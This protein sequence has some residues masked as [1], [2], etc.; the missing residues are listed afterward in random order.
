MRAFVTR[1]TAVERAARINAGTYVIR[2]GSC[3]HAMRKKPARASCEN[4]PAP[5]RTEDAIV[6]DIR[7]AS[8]RYGGTHDSLRV[9]HSY[10]RLFLARRYFFLDGFF[11]PIFRRAGVCAACG[12]IGPYDSHSASIPRVLISEV[13][14]LPFLS[15]LHVYGAENSSCYIIYARW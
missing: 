9:A 15:L 3:A 7:E 11:L 8:Q 14:N 10:S 4:S 2:K 6:S 12:R 1:K 5:G 13:L